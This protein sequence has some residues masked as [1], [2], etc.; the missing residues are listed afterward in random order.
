[1]GEVLGGGAWATLGAAARA[2]AA[3]LAQLLELNGEGH[4]DSET[5]A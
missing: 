4:N 2:R 5:S 3:D 1:M